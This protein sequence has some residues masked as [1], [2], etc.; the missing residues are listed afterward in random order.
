VVEKLKLEVDSLYFTLL[1]SRG[2][3]GNSLQGLRH[4]SLIP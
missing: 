4:I 1:P 3:P 2:R